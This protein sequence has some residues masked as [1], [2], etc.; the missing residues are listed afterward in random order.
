VFAPEAQDCLDMD[1]DTSI[2]SDDDL[3]HYQ[4]ANDRFWC[5][6]VHARGRLHT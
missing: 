1:M 6:L 3:E 4:G 2:L 5:D